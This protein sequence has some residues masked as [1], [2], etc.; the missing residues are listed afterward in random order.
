MD[1]QG[2]DYFIWGIYW[3]GK[4]DWSRGCGERVYTRI[5]NCDRQPITDR[6]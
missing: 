1:W 6:F 3:E 4:R 2:S 5:L